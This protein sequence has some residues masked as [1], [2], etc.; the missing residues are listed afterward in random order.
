MKQAFY[1][2]PKNAND[3]EIV[4]V[5]ENIEGYF[6]LDKKSPFYFVG[7]EKLAEDLAKTFNKKYHNLNEKQA[8]DIVI[9]SMKKGV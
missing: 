4:L 9:T 3:F 5:K 6:I 8:L 1:T 2:V 7:S